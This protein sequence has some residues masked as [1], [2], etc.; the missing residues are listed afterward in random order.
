MKKHEW[1]ILLATLYLLVYVI[2]F[3]AGATL[4]QISIMFVLSPVPVFY[5]VY[6]I[7]KAPYKGKTLQEGQEYGYADRP[8]PTT[9][10]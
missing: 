1:A 9:I 10:M 6:C 5:M 3:N 8:N 4:Q 7:L 2:W